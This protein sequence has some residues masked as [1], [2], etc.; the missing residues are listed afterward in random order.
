MVSTTTSLDLPPVLAS[1][2]SNCFPLHSK[3]VRKHS[4]VSNRTKQILFYMCFRNKL[5]NTHKYVI[6]HSNMIPNKQINKKYI[7]QST[8]MAVQA[9]K[10]H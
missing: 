3:L 7:L 4:K 9:S 6:N 2:N 8:V 10:S 5:L 1:P